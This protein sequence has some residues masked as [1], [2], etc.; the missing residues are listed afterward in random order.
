MTLRWADVDRAAGELR[1]RDAKTGPRMVLLT[2]ELEVVFA[3]IPRVPG[4]PRVIVGRKPGAGLTDITYYW[5]RL[6]RG[7]GWT[8]CGSMTSDILV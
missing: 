7:P 2:P 4:N 1:L 5:Y 8:T 3:D 6:R